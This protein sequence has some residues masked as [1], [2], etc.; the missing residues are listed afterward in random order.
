MKQII[1]VL[2]LL[3]TININSQKEKI[4]LPNGYGFEVKYSDTSITPIFSVYVTK[5][6]KTS[7][8]H[9]NLPIEKLG[10]TIFKYR[11]EVRPDLVPFINHHI[12]ADKNTPYKY[13]DAVKEQMSRA[14]MYSVMYRTDN[15]DDISKGITNKLHRYLKPAIKEHGEENDLIFGEIPIVR[16]LEDEIIENLYTLQIEQA[17]LKLNKFKYVV[18]TIND[19]ES[20]LVNNKKI[21]LKEEEQIYDA[22]KNNDF[23]II[24]VDENLKYEAY[25][26]NLTTIVKSY[27]KYEK[28]ISLFE[29]SIGLQ[30]ILKEKNIKL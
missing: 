26:K 25:I 17:K 15:I 8:E 28:H 19:S 14:Q 7:L 22:M 21:L 13:V 27:K 4:E 30:K 29:I 9:I 3:F 23:F 10:D 1:L 2:I 16:S 20:L 24:S 5:E 18:I 6:G 11:N 12:Y